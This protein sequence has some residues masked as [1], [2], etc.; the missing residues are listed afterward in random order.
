L[1]LSYKIAVATAGDETEIIPETRGQLKLPGFSL[2]QI[3]VFCHD[4]K[5]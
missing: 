2:T 3:A 1:E 5:A 4:D